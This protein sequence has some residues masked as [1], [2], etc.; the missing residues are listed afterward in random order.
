MKAGKFALFILTLWAIIAA[1]LL[2]GFILKPDRAVP[3]TTPPPTPACDT[4][5]LTKRLD[6]QQKLVDKLRDKL[7]AQT[8]ACATHIRE[9]ESLPGE[10]ALLTR[11]VE[12]QSDRIA[13]LEKGL[14]LFIKERLA[15]IGH[16]SPDGERVNFTF[17][18][19]GDAWSDTWE[20]EK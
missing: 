18:P 1:G 11:T 6:D 9:T 12:E 4:S 8:K 5:T 16:H 17:M 10:V 14:R 2:V 19:S 3:E 13:H 7:K 20:V 15:I